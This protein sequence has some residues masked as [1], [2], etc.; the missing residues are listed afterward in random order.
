MDQHRPTS[1]FRW[2]LTPALILLAI[3]A[4]VVFAVILIL[5][6]LWFALAQL[7]A[8]ALPW[9][10]VETSTLQAV[11]PPHFPTVPGRVLEAHTPQ[12]ANDKQA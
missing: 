7:I 4:L 9:R 10:R 5:R 11:Q 1:A 3:P 2:L 12:R 8:S 6:A